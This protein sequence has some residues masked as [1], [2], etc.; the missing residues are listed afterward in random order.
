MTLAKNISKYSDF[1]DRSKY[2]ED[3]KN[4]IILLFRLFWNIDKSVLFISKLH[5]RY[6]KMIYPL[7]KSKQKITN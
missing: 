2:E 1:L 5:I 3:G 4:G 7:N 6:I